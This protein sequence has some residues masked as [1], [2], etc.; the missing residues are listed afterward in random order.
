MW[1]DFKY[2]KVIL[3][4]CCPTEQHFSNWGL[5]TNQGSQGYTPRGLQ[6]PW[7]NRGQDLL[8]DNVKMKPSQFSMNGNKDVTPEGKEL[9]SPFPR[10]AA[11]RATATHTHLVSKPPHSTSQ[12]TCFNCQDIRIKKFHCFSGQAGTVVR[13]T[14]GTFQC[15]GLHHGD[16][17][18]T[19]HS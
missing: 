5:G 13:C 16:R 15:T 4:L 14:S 8:I 19:L 10:V 6:V 11:L 9:P 3:A 18:A 1:S 17:D 2:Y 12:K 7:K